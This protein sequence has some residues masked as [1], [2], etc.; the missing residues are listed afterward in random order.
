MYPTPNTMYPTHIPSKCFPRFW[1][2]CM[3]LRLE[4]SSEIWPIC[5]LISIPTCGGFRRG[6]HRSIDFGE[7]RSAK[8]K[9]MSDGFPLSLVGVWRTSP[10]KISE[11]RLNWWILLTFSCLEYLWNPWADFDKLDLVGKLLK[12][13][14]IWYRSW[15]GGG[16]A[17]APALKV[18]AKLHR[19]YDG[20][21]TGSWT[22]S[23]RR[24]QARGYSYSSRQTWN[25]RTLPIALS[26]CYA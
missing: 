12:S 16:G 26:L 2:F 11:N 14:T 23:N 17:R 22:L 3:N 21:L 7:T 8:G 9:D 4:S 5:I 18:I 13:T 10:K 1:A 15:P 25:G 24:A 20:L 6:V 19:L